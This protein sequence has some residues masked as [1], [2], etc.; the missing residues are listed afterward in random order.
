MV[1]SKTLKKETELISFLEETGTCALHGETLS[2]LG[3][4]KRT[5]RRLVS[6][7]RT[8][9]TFSAIVLIRC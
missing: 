9:S 6:S 4:S 7:F 8:N 5:R 1:S 2:R 3:S